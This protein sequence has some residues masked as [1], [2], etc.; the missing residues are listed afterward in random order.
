MALD[1]NDYEGPKSDKANEPGT[2]LA[3]VS[4]AYFSD[5]Y[6]PAWM[7]KL[8]TYGHGF[9]NYKVPVEEDGVTPKTTNRNGEKTP[10]WRKRL[11]DLFRSANMPSKEYWAEEQGKRKPLPN[12]K[13]F[14]EAVVGRELVVRLGFGDG[15]YSNILQVQ[16][17]QPFDESKEEHY[18]FGVNTEAKRRVDIGPV[19]EAGRAAVSQAAQGQWESPTQDVRDDEI[20]F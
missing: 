13:E 5:T 2:F 17:L 20:P 11:L 7:F 12:T 9:V 1:T 16:G 6:D 4:R 10:W 19:S 14:Y 15:A 18:Q 3:K 8:E